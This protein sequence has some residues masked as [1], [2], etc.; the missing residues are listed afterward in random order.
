MGDNLK[1]LME[2][3]VE[4]NALTPSTVSSD[5]VK[6]NIQNIN[7]SALQKTIQTLNAVPYSDTQALKINPEEYEDYNVTINRFDEDLDK[8]RAENQSALEQGFNSL[9][10][11][12]VGEV[13]IG[14]PLGASD[15][16]DAVSGAVFRSNNDYSNPVSRTLEKWQEEFKNATPIYRTNP[17][18][19]F[20]ITDT[21]WWFSNL[22]S[23]A[24]SLS[25]LLPAVGTA[26]ALSLAGKYTRVAKGFEKAMKAAKFKPSQI[27]TA[28]HW[29]EAGTTAA[30]SRTMENYREA[31]GTY[32][33]VNEQTLSELNNMSNEDYAK[34]LENNPQYANQSKEDIANDIA[35]KA[36]DRTFLI[37][38][39]NI[40]FDVMQL[41]AL[42]NVWK[43]LRNRPS[44]G[45]L[46]QTNK[47]AAETIGKTATEIA[48]QKAKKTFADK[49]VDKAK[50]F[51]L[52]SY[53]TTMAELSEGVEEGINYIAQEEGNTYGKQLLGEVTNPFDERIQ[54]YLSNGEL[55][56]SAFWG[57]LG[58]VIFQGLGSQFGKFKNKII[59]KETRTE[60]EVRKAEILGRNAKWE[61]YKSDIEKI[62]EG[63]DIYN[64][65]ENGNFGTFEN[66]AYQDLA[67]KKREDEF[68]VDIAMNAANAGNI[69]YL[70]AYV[71]DENV[72]KVF[73]DLENATRQK[74]NQAPLNKEEEANYSQRILDKIQE[75]EDLYDKNILLL[76]NKNVEPEYAQIIAAEN[77]RKDITIKSLDRE[78]AYY[79]NEIARLMSE[80]R[81]SDNVPENAQEYINAVV[82]RTR[83]QFLNKER[84]KLEKDNTISGIIG[85]R[86]IDKEIDSIKKSL[87]DDDLGTS[88]IYDSFITEV[89]NTEEKAKA[90]KWLDEKIEKEGPNVDKVAREAAITQQRIKTFGIYDDVANISQDLADYMVNKAAYEME[91]NTLANTKT[92]TEDDIKVKRSEISNSIDEI[93]AKAVN[94]STKNI[95]DL[96]QKYD[97][98]EVLRY[99]NNENNEISNITNEDKQVLDESLNILK[100]DAEENV[101]LY[102]D[103]VKLGVTI[104]I[105]KESNANRVNGEKINNPTEEPE[106][107]IEE[108]TNL[109]PSSTPTQSNTQQPVI[110]Q[111]NPTDTSTQS[112]QQINTSSNK[113]APKP[114]EALAATP[115]EDAL[116]N[117][118]SS[119]I[120]KLSIN[121]DA[122]LNLLKDEVVEDYIKQGFK[123][124]DIEK[125]LTPVI[126]GVIKRRQRA[127]A[128]NRNAAIVETFEDTAYDLLL[129]SSIEESTESI[130]Y[131]NSVD[132][133]I[134]KYAQNVGLKQTNGKTFIN[135]ENLMRY[136]QNNTSDKDLANIIFGGL[137]Q[138]LINQ[139]N[140]NGKYILT[141]E[142]NVEKLNKQDFFNNVNKT[143]E[144]RIKERSNE[145][146]KQRVDIYN[147][148]P[149]EADEYDKF[150]DALNKVQKD[151]I[152][153]PVVAEGEIQ[154]LYN[155]VKIGRLPIPYIDPTTG[156][157]KMRN[158]GWIYT[159][160]RN[161]GKV[162]SP[163]KDLMTEWLITRSDEAEVEELN[164]IINQIAY[165]KGLSVEEKV[166][167]INRF[168][169]NKEII[170]A[171]SNG[172]ID[173]NAN[174]EEL[175]D[176][177][178]SIYGYVSQDLENEYKYVSIEQWFDKLQ[179]SYEG[180]TNLLNGNK[181]VKVAEISDGELIY[182]DEEKSP[183]E[184]IVNFNPKVNKMMIA[185]ENNYLSVSGSTQKIPW[186]VKRG[187][188]FV[189]IPNRNG[190]HQYAQATPVKLN[191]DN[192]SKEAK[193]IREEIK[194]QIIEMYKKKSSG[195]I[196]F[197]EFVSF[198]KGLFSNGRGNTS[199]LGGVVTTYTDNGNYI[200]ISIPNT[201]VGLTFYNKTKSGAN[202]TKVGLLNNQGSREINDAEVNNLVNQIVDNS[203]FLISF[204]G[205]KS[206]ASQAFPF[207]NNP[208]IFKENGKFTIKIGDKTWNYDSFSDFLL[209]NDLV[210]VHVGKT[211]DG[212]SNFR[213]IATKT[214]G[215][216]ILNI[217]IEDVVKTPVESVEDNTINSKIQNILNNNRIKNKG[218][219]IAELLIDKSTKDLFKRLGIIPENIK[220]VDEVLDNKG[221]PVILQVNVKTKEVKL[222]NE[223]LN[224]AENDPKQAFRKLIHEGIHLKIA[225]NPSILSEIGDIFDE[226]RS[227]AI[228]LDDSDPIRKY[229][230]NQYNGNVQLEEFL[231]ESLTSKELM[232]FLNNTQS[233]ITDKAGNKLSLFQKILNALAKLVGID[234]NKD[235]L[236]EK[237]FIALGDK[238]SSEVKTNIENSSEINN[239]EDLIDNTIQ[240]VIDN[241]INNIEVEENNDIV[242]DEFG[243]N[244]DFDDFTLDIETDEFN[245]SIK[246]YDGT[247]TY[248]NMQAYIE[249]INPFDQSKILEFIENGEL[250]YACR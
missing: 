156:A 239:E 240:Q 220:F 29:V 245:S 205:I 63:K 242:N 96:F 178:A 97:T 247:K 148:T 101:V 51:G 127:E 9:A 129:N 218:S 34:W 12:I 92:V 158:N 200:T 147:V 155:N 206:D 59:G 210:T 126:N 237:E 222:T 136:T 216:Q 154:L 144:Q 231:V 98:N 219:K 164:Y 175:L 226:F 22:P 48:E 67:R 73:S 44:T 45:V 146:I 11:T 173:L 204:S 223:F 13:L 72:N 62:N 134:N 137:K 166:D 79:D 163:L 224:L 149:N 30:A 197:N 71:Q 145:I 190:R 85:K 32:D 128:Q 141:D 221:N 235:S 69:D 189:L 159:I 31:R 41:H 102:D 180:V 241:K 53:Y 52:G 157:Y 60:E 150:E 66:D 7:E 143:S 86:A 76:D 88:V 211:K 49:A 55:W 186:N 169:N 151:D 1:R 110:P 250:N 168:N 203:N 121:K 188:T 58:G 3:G 120:K 118:G 139:S 81:I 185:T 228:K 77:T 33:Q 116:E 248:P 103:L 104:Q 108:P 19:S 167:L 46:S 229:L 17:N 57:V 78:I 202:A 225:E 230:L 179:N 115:D 232:T 56:E 161:N 112:S 25:L 70:K 37:D 170:N 89:N 83:L 199:L 113:P 140:T 75:V 184:S 162:Q 243:E 28:K 54:S 87:I 201:T 82:K 123:R 187:S 61:K 47:E 24:S 38:Y 40:V 246:E 15:L 68:I 192:I 236:L 249:S 122:D 165:N 131:Q 194:K 14:I 238:L 100:L 105:G 212:K 5:A 42:K 2:Q 36:A 50:Q 90:Q 125:R 106:A 196:T 16:V 177:L 95:I 117:V 153:T 215:N 6:S 138:Y 114:D 21:G 107:P 133:Y 198:I 135:L 132:N 94:S 213:R 183:R 80:Q 182:T 43:G 99:I 191:N 207:G 4:Q 8:Q 160:S 84:K 65:D 26:K 244:N 130:N 111:P 174:S 234:I 39:S 64:I 227:I 124:E 217:Q 109:A 35:S 195:E 10:Q 181:R 91:R 119:F 142:S 74:N 18:K 20:D 176:G 233:K 23:V 208:V 152:L 193:E 93:R 172:F 171:K 209:N 27:S 214:G